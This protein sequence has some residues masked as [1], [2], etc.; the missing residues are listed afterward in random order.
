[1][2]GYQSA[3]YA[4]SL[5]AFGRPLHLP[6]CRGWVLERDIA[7]TGERDAMGCYPLFTCANWEG[8]FDD[9]GSLPGRL[10]SLSMVVDP[11]TPLSEAELRANFDVT[12]PFKEH[13]VAD[14]HTFDEANV[15]KHHR[16][17]SRRA[18]R[19]LTVARETE[20]SSRLDHWCRLYSVLVNRHE[21][22]GIKAFS[23]ES[24]AAQLAVPGLV[25]FM[26][27]DRHGPVGAHLWFVE[28]NVAYSHLAAFD[29]VGY[30]SGAAYALYWEAIRT[31]RDEMRDCVRWI[32]FGAGAG[33]S[34]DA[35]DGLT[36]F[37]RGWASTTRTKFFCGRVFDKQRYDR[38]TVAAGAFGVRYFPAYRYGEF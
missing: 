36:A 4:Q 22:N 32:D 5:S 8:L 18:L 16:Y 25:M 7:G 34:S 28:N 2:I 26:A 11:F 15:S 20:P 13:F 21:L 6:G 30:A 37:K 1:M 10:V 3:A 33:T 38:L 35:A 17:Y 27:S 9:L 12:L 23:R 19:A 14:A 29:D 31:F 24:F